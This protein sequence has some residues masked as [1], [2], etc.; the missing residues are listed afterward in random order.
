[1]KLKYFG[2]SNTP[3]YYFKLERVT[4]LSVNK[5]IAFSSDT[6]HSALA[7]RRCL[8]SSF[9]KSIVPKA[10]SVDDILIRPTKNHSTDHSTD[11]I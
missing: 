10:R 9:G 1:M 8:M 4:D 5:T 7:L 6:L 2:A 3:L 11:D